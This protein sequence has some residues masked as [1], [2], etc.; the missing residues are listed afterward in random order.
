MVGVDINI[1]I[2]GSLLIVPGI[3]LGI[4]GAVGWQRI[5]VMVQLSWT[6]PELV[7]HIHLGT[8]MQHTLAC[9]LV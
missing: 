5:D 6:R 4:L 1:E 2:A 8:R 7:I 9:Q 3:S